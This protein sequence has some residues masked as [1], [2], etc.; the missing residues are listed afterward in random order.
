MYYR[1]PERKGLERWRNRKLGRNV[2]CV[3]ALVGSAL[4]VAGGL[5][6]NT[7]EVGCEILSLFPVHR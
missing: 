4:V 5:Q 6:K 3:W 1:A 7:R 2:S